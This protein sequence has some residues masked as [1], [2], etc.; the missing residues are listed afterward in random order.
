MKV[1]IQYDSYDE[2]IDKVGKL[3]DIAEQ[4]QSHV[5]RFLGELDDK[6]WTGRG[7][8]AFRRE[9]T[10]DILPAVNDLESAL[11]TI[12]Q[13][14]GRARDI[15]REAEQRAAALFRGDIAALVGGVVAGAMAGASAVKANAPKVYTEVPTRDGQLTG[16]K[17]AKILFINGI[18][19]DGQGHLDGLTDISEMYGGQPVAGVFNATSD[20]VSLPLI[21]KLPGSSHIIDMFQA[22]DDWAEAW[23]GHRFVNNPAVDSMMQWIKDNPDGQIVAHSQGAAITSAALQNLERQGFDL[24]KL[25]VRILGGAGPVFPDG[26]QYESFENV[27]D[28]VPKLTRFLNRPLQILFPDKVH[29]EISGFGFSFGDPIGHGIDTYKRL[30]KDNVS[31]GG[32]GSW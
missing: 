10:D 13:T 28:P 21:G 8:D 22:A 23:T 27:V 3:R 16:D 18:G 24:S 20:G 30:I 29:E 12:I 14:M 4:H 25:K 1:R 6:R 5:H 32:G 15:L 31:S 7:A 9:L 19:T 26:P 11:A 17:D 2:L